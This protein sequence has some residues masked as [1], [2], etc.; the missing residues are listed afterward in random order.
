MTR[1]RLTTRLIHQGNTVL[2]K[3]CEKL[4]S[5]RHFHTQTLLEPAIATHSRFRI[6]EASARG[7]TQADL[8]TLVLFGLTHGFV[9]EAAS[10]KAFACLTSSHSKM[11]ATWRRRTDHTSRYAFARRQMLRS[12]REIHAHAKTLLVATVLTA[13]S[14]FERQRAAGVLTYAHVGFAWIFR[15]S[16]VE[17]FLK[18][19]FSFSSTYLK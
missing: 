1:M 3:M 15:L 8:L 9:H 16:A 19:K 10:E 12:Q 11:N 2:Y 17:E 7:R 5:N 4:T 13:A 18:Q 14:I 6:Y